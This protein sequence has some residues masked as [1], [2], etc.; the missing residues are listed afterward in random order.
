MWV[1]RVGLS[2]TQQQRPV[3]LGPHHAK[4]RQTQNPQS[5]GA[6][7]IPTSAALQSVKGPW[8]PNCGGTASMAAGRGQPHRFIPTLPR[9]WQATGVPGTFLL[10]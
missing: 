10:P 3:L 2:E 1:L 9:P 7:D 6:A 5:S 8:R 4:L